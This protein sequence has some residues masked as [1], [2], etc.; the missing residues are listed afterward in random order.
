MYTGQY[1]GIIRIDFHIDEDKPGIQP[2][3]ELEE[4]ITEKLSAM[5]QEMVSEELEGIA[6]V[7]VTAQEACLQKEGA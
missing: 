5:L 3:K 6:D 7:E 1:I 2:F 4:T